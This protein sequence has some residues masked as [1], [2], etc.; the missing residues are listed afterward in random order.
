MKDLFSYFSTLIHFNKASIVILVINYLS[1]SLKK[2]IIY[3]RKITDIY[4]G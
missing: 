4:V 3:Q 2:E 1:H